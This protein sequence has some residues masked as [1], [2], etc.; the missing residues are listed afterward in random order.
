MRWRPTSTTWVKISCCLHD[1]ER[2]WETGNGHRICPKRRF[3]DNLD[4]RRNA[5]REIVIT[6]FLQYIQIFTLLF[7]HLF[8]PY[9]S[10]PCSDG[11]NRISLN[12]TLAL[13]SKESTQSSY[14][15]MAMVDNHVCVIHQWRSSFTSSSWARLR[16]ACAVNDKT[17]VADVL[18]DS[19]VEC[20]IQFQF[21][22]VPCDSLMSLCI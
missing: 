17:D 9:L 15:F 3:C 12:N 22:N 7:S 11:T 10:L 21:C 18:M 16:S 19:G 1:L 5:L 6:R 8:R 4:A 20:S 13:T 14:I 2:C